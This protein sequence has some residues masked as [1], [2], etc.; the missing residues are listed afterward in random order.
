MKWKWMVTETVILTNMTFCAVLR[1]TC[2]VNDH[3]LFIHLYLFYL[4]I[5]AKLG[6]FL[7]H[8]LCEKEK[9]H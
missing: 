9:I 1:K 2:E 8:S 6:I 3:I 5:T 7:G 4:P